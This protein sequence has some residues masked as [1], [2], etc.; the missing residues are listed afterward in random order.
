MRGRVEAVSRTRSIITS[1]QAGTN[2]VLRRNIEAIEDQEI[3]VGLRPEK[4]VISK[5]KPEDYNPNKPVNCIK[6]IVEDIAY[7]GGLSTYH[8]RTANGNIIKSTDFNIERN[9]DHP[10]W[11]DEVYLT[12]ESENIMVLYS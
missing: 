9:A 10:S 12:W 1:E 4:I 11:D 3:W 5:D 8:V 6:G 7:M 2:F